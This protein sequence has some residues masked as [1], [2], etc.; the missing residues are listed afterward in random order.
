[1][2]GGAGFKEL[3]AADE[4][5]KAATRSSIN[6]PDAAFKSREIAL[7]V[8]CLYLSLSV[9]EETA[10]SGGFIAQWSC[11]RAEDAIRGQDARNTRPVW[12]VT[13][14]WREKRARRAAGW[15]PR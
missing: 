15:L 12:T 10:P 8:A 14:W 6:P 5:E 9:H 2:L 11:S 3:A 7:A 1:M 13:L 4:E